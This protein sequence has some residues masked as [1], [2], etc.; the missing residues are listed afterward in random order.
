MEDLD[1]R[2]GRNIDRSQILAALLLRLDP[3]QRKTVSSQGR[4][5]LEK[6][7]S[8]AH[9]PTKRAEKDLKP[10]LYFRVPRLFDEAGSRQEQMGPT[11][12]GSMRLRDASCSC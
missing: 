2:P 9:S 7:T 11:R 10:R 4:Q 1:L 12:A 5:G 3:P 8:A 6:A